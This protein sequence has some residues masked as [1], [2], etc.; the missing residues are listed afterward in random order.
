MIWKDVFIQDPNFVIAIFRSMAQEARNDVESNFSRVSYALF[1]AFEVWSPEYKTD[2][3]LVRGVLTSGLSM[4]E[5]KSLYKEIYLPNKDKITPHKNYFL[6]II[7]NQGLWGTNFLRN[8]FFN[9]GGIYDKYFVKDPAGVTK[10]IVLSGQAGMA[11][12]MFRLAMPLFEDEFKKDGC[13]PKVE[14]Y[15]KAYVGVFRR[16]DK[17]DDAKTARAFKA[18][19]P[20]IKD[21]PEIM[22][23]LG[24]FVVDNDKISEAYLTARD[25]IIK[26]PYDFVRFVN[27][28]GDNMYTLR[29]K[30]VMAWSRFA[31]DFGKNGYTEKMK[32]SWELVMKMPFDGRDVFAMVFP[33]CEKFPKQADTMMSDV[34]ENVKKIDIGAF[35]RFVFPPIE[36]DFS[37]NGYTPKIK[38]YLKVMADA[39]ERY[40]DW[41]VRQM[42]LMNLA[43]EIY[44]GGLQKRHEEELTFFYDHV[45]HKKIDRD[46]ES[47]FAMVRAFFR[48]AKLKEK[49]KTIVSE[50]PNDV[51][52]SDVLDQFHHR[53]EMAGSADFAKKYFFLTPD[54]PQRTVVEDNFPISTDQIN[55][56]VG[57]LNAITRRTT[58]KIGEGGGN[59][60][61]TLTSYRF[62][63][64]YGS[65]AFQSVLQDYVTA[66]P[67]E[68]TFMNSFSLAHAVTRRIFQERREMSEEN[69][70]ITAREVLESR[71][72]VAGRE[73]FGPHTKLIV[74][75]HEEPHFSGEKIINDLFLHAGGKRENVLCS[76]K[77]LDV[78][79]GKN[80]AKERVLASI[81]N[82][83]AG[84]VTLVFD[85]HGSEENWAFS[86]NHPAELNRS[87]Y[88]DPKTINYRELGDALIESGNIREFNILGMTCLAYNYLE[89][90]FEYLEEKG[91]KEKPFISISAGN[92]AQFSY[93]QTHPESVG[94]K[95][96]QNVQSM[97]EKGKPVTVRDVWRAEGRVWRYED[98][99]FFIQDNNG[100]AFE[101]SAV[102]SPVAVDGEARPA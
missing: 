3:A 5:K 55:L 85:G 23:S 67:G 24:D 32:K 87:I 99:A 74:F 20:D 71:E 56:F 53:E 94:S 40:D 10:M 26:N 34:R 95:F 80:L 60:L 28:H 29:E 65:K 43:P 90:L 59:E 15:W 7:D 14:S 82:A 83:K 75:A 50:T 25:A 66:H 68:L 93:A 72:H 6:E 9:A 102:P 52:L 33:G 89:N 13:S 35:F 11:E 77:G 19:W 48:D 12:S 92:N 16:F 62:T 41:D 63:E 17:N 31:Y 18:L 51:D 64:M 84:P 4:Y 37:R 38:K 69:I 86:E 98:P 30:I 2:P 100:K 58:E 97:M 36:S 61:F 70:E 79:D 47:Y 22:E 73:I 81:R 76:E 1:E 57:R 46:R 96:L 45:R 27:E 44:S 42:I 21:H 54:L 101:I 8:D 78:Q 91:V 88:D 39:C 49:I